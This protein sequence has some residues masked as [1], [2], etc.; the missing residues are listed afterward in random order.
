MTNGKKIL[1][2]LPGCCAN[3]RRFTPTLAV[4]EVHLLILELQ[5][6]GQASGW[7][8]IKELIRLLGLA[9]HHFPL[10]LYL[11]PGHHLKGTGTKG[12][13][14]FVAPKSVVSIFVARP[15][16]QR[17]SQDHLDLSIIRLAEVMLA[18]P[19]GCIYLHP[20]KVAA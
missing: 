11:A 5:P 13:R 8:H 16:R 1:G 17:T 10:Y 4:K 12:T 2:W 14:K 20:V 3:R 19:Q 9:G 15:P 6:E 18:V 7:T